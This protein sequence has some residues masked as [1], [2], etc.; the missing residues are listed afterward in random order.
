MVTAGDDWYALSPTGPRPLVEEAR[1]ERK[2]P[3][4]YE[5]TKAAGGSS[6]AQV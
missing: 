5:F 2:R 3:K 1:D 4:Q 6:R